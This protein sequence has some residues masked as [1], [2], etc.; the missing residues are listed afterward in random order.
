MGIFDRFPY[1]ST[2]EMN[3]DFMLGKATEIAEEMQQ[4]T[5]GMAQVQAGLSAISEKT[6]QATQA[7][8]QA[9]ASASSIE[10]SVTAAEEAAEE[11]Q[12]HNESAQTWA[13][14]ALTYK[15][16]CQRAATEAA[17]SSSSAAQAAT[18]A[19]ASEDTVAQYAQAANASAQSAANNNDSAHQYA[20]QASASAS[21]ATFHSSNAQTAATNA[22]TAAT[23][24]NTSATNASASADRAASLK[25][26]VETLH[27]MCAAA[28]DQ[29]A[30]EAV[31]A[32][33]SAAQAAATKTDV[34]T[35]VESLPEDFTDLN[36]TVNQLSF[37]ID[38]YIKKG[39]TKTLVSS[40]FGQGAFSGTTG[41]E[42][43]L[44]RIRLR[45][46]VSLAKGTTIT[47]PQNGLYYMVWCLRN[48]DLTSPDLIK[49][50][51]WAQYDTLTIDT[52]CYVEIACAT[53]ST[54]ADS[55][56]IVPSDFTGTIG[57]TEPNYTRNGLENANERID[58]I[59]I[60]SDGIEELYLSDFIQAASGLSGFNQSTQ[61]LSTLDCVALPFGHRTK[62]QIKINPNYVVGIRAGRTAQNLASNKYWY[63]NGDTVTFT[64]HEQY[65][66]IIIAKPSN[67]SA[68]AYYTIELSELPDID[69][70]I[71]YSFDGGT[72][73]NAIDANADNL[74]Y[75]VNSEN[76]LSASSHGDTD[77]HPVILHISDVHGDKKRTE[78]AL[79]IAE[80]IG[81]DCSI[82]SGD[83]VANSPIQGLQWMHELFSSYSGLPIICTGNHD[84][85]NSEYT[86]ADVYNYMM[87]PSAE[88]IGNTN[89]TTYYYTDIASKKIRV[90]VTDIYQYGA[91]TRSNAH[92]STEQLT[93]ICNA[94]ASTPAGYGVI[95]VAHTP[96]VN[97]SNLKD[98]AYPTFFQS[99][100]KYGF[101]HYDINGAPIYDIV[102]AFIARSTINRT[103]TQ[104]GT[105]STITASGDFTGV[106]TNVEFIAHITG[107]IHEDSV[108]YLPTAQKQLMLNICCG[109]CMNGG[110]YYPYLADDCDITRL[111]YG[112]T[113]DAINIYVIDRTNKLVK[114]T[115]I[116]GTKTYDMKD[117][118][119]MEIPYAD[120]T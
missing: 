13:N 88:K 3:L 98:S 2:H 105:P 10:G 77:T 59:K 83:I 82:I 29:A 38:Q 100:R 52:D 22:Q 120:A 46:P 26:D 101:S 118:E 44:I 11:A 43:S 112:K 30:T 119:Y 92:M 50:F 23:N 57:I 12:M 24:A 66:R 75:W 27:R 95:I 79:K 21:N 109:N 111:P 34:E 63:R 96:C 42:Y 48:N 5:A 53:A 20:N 40:D 94:L 1:S 39:Y 78:T 64:A 60:K 74:Q 99:L 31:N 97:V 89:G 87:S 49:S 58:E 114:I 14:N 4:V 7:A 103:Y 65:Y 45:E 15:A 117:R 41:I 80:Y 85:D 51:E 106:P 76:V 9:A 72:D 56:N 90:I 67:S 37:D 102:D 68:T 36:N 104:S 25:T 62:L 71:Y 18:A 81:A 28:V 16:D 17:A 35:L 47:F 33:N 73:R 108:C 107:H 86:D 6:E 55:D 113:Q 115:R 54:Y 93:Y 69:L 70:H 61:R 91:T 8:A 110:Q 116:G 84:V 32:A 19:A